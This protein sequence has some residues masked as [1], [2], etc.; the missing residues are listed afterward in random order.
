MEN[1]FRHSQKPLENESDNRKEGC[2]DPHKLNIY[3]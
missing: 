2:R 1:I 3:E